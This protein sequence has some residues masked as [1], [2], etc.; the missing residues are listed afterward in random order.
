MK[1]FKTRFIVAL[2]VIAALTWIWRGNS[3]LQDNIGPVIKYTA[4]KNYDVLGWGKSMWAGLNQKTQPAVST[5]GFQLPCAYT[6]ITRHFGWYYNPKTNTQQFNPGVF[7]EIGKDTLIY[8]VLRGK[9]SRV[10]SQENGYQVIIQHGGGLVSMIRGLRETDL[11]KGALVE[12]DSV[13][14]SASDLIYL[15][16]RGREGPVDPEGFLNQISSI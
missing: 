13:L 11:K 15:E 4:T 2:V 7:L 12:E 16:I 3:G 5:S 1:G 10:V 6:G 8:P 9:V 14:G